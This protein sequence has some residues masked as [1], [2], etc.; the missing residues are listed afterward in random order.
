[1]GL[2]PFV[3]SNMEPDYSPTVQELQEI[4][5]QLAQ[6]I[7]EVLQ[8]YGR[9]QYENELQTGKNALKGIKSLLEKAKR[10]QKQKQKQEAA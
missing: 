4:H 6:R 3:V 10:E 7:E 8:L 2:S 1:M 5:D 9:D